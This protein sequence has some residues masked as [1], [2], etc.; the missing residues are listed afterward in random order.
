MTTNLPAGEGSNGLYEVHVDATANPNG[1]DL[2]EDQD[3]DTQLQAAME[4]VGIE[5]KS[6]DIPSRAPPSSSKTLVQASPKS[7][8]LF[9]KYYYV[10]SY[11]PL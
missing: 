8:S 11:I 5:M 4:Q 6:D 1:D 10:R 9:Q 3:E 7:Q 2:I